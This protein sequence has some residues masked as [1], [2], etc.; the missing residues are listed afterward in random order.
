MSG[1]DIPV[2]IRER[3]VQ[4]DIEATISVIVG[5]TAKPHRNTLCVCVCVL[6]VGKTSFP[7]A[8]FLTGF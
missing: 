1:A 8:P 6:F 2:P 5:V 7:H 3:I 4:I